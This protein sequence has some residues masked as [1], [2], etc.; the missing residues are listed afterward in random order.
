ME[1]AIGM[2]N[3]KVM[4]LVYLALAGYYVPQNKTMQWNNEKKELILSLYTYI[5]IHYT[6]C[7]DINSI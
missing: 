4:F 7:Q 6:S 2:K 1:I 3:C 5:Q